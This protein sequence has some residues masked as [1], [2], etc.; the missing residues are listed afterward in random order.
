[1]PDNYTLDNYYAEV[2]VKRKKNNNKIKAF[3][4]VSLKPLPQ[5]T[6]T[7]GNET[8]KLYISGFNG[9]IDELLGGE[10]WKNY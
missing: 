8:M 1:M 2:V 4:H 9:C 3:P 10:Q 5:K 6:K 7:W